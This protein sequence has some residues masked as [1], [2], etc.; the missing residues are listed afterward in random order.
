MRVTKNYFDVFAVR[1]ALYLFETI[2]RYIAFP[3]IDHFQTAEAAIGMD[4]SQDRFAIDSAPLNRA[5][6]VGY[7]GFAKGAGYT[8]LDCGH[9]R[10]LTGRTGSHGNKQ[11]QAR[12]P[13]RHAFPLLRRDA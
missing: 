10:L 3:A 1:A 5:V 9:V 6:D 4:D 2:G 11:T 13:Q 12:Y 7:F 8:F